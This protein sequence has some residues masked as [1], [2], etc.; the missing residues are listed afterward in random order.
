MANSLQLAM[1]WRSSCLTLAGDKTRQPPKACWRGPQVAKRSNLIAGTVTAG[2]Q[3]GR[4]DRLWLRGSGDLLGFASST[5]PTW[6]PS[7]PSP[8]PPA[9]CMP[10]RPQGASLKPPPKKE[11]G[12]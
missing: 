9:L 10:V 6:L 4:Q 11:K 1:G 3:G 7:T 12:S 5:Q 2:R 8:P